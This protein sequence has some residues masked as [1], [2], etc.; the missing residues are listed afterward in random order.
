MPVDK[1]TQTEPD[2]GYI[3]KVNGITIHTDHQSLTAGAILILAQRDN[4]IPG[5]PEDYLL[6]GDKGVYQPGDI[7]DLEQDNVFIAIRNKETPVAR[8]SPPRL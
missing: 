2:N 1:A 7:I 8:Y 6:Q 3:L 5:K 4:A